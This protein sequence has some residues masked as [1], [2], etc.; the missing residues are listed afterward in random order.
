MSEG[1]YRLGDARIRLDE[2]DALAADRHA[3]LGKLGR[4]MLPTRL[5]VALELARSDADRARVEDDL[6]SRERA[7]L[8]WTRELD[9]AEPEAARARELLPLDPPARTGDPVPYLFEEPA[10]ATLRH[11]LDEAARALGYSTPTVRL[12]DRAYGMSI[13]VDGAP[14]AVRIHDESLERSNVTRSQLLDV[15]AFT[16]VCTNIPRGLQ[17]IDV[18]PQ[19]WRHAV[20]EG[21][22]LL[23][24]LKLGDSA[25]DAAF[26]V[27]CPEHLG[28]LLFQG[29]VRQALLDAQG[30]SSLQLE[31]GVARIVFG[32]AMLDRLAGITQARP[33]ALVVDA[34]RALSVLRRSLLQLG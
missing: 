27:R 13:D 30:F 11:R 19:K 29:E 20:G 10:M 8:V 32:T 6:A 34:A 17:G 9:E 26:F 33:A 25:F 12:G 31:G 1:P 18:R 4:A 23:H 21:L 22:G 5:R 7:L 3:A 2:L 16:A 24:E 15:D 28:S 14:I